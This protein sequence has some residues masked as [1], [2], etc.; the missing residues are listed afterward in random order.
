MLKRILA[1]ALAVALFQT[2][3]L[4]AQSS[5]N[6]ATAKTITQVNKWGV[7]KKVTVTMLDGNTYKGKITQISSES[8]AVFD[9]SRSRE[10]S[11]AYSGIEEI[12]GAR[13]RFVKPLIITG[14]VFSLLAIGCAASDCGNQ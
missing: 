13:R 11:V 2:P 7:G 5:T 4:H 14:I 10:A 1:A 6:P 12:K 8:F 9:E 3:Q